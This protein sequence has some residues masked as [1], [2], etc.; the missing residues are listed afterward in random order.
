[1]YQIILVIHIVLSLAIIGL[2]LMQRGKG[3]DMG[4]SF[5][6]GASQTLFGSGGS[7]SFLTR[8][9][10]LLATGFYITCLVLSYVAVHI[11]K[12]NSA[13]YLPEI[14]V[15]VETVAPPVSD[16]P[17]VLPLTPAAEDS[18]KK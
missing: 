10:G 5:G 14:P 15:A 17:S 8:T 9:T 7:G 3:A 18:S 11:S 2:V 6:A 13:D 4:A 12:G 16:L 1:M